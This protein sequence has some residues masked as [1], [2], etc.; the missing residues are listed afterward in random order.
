MHPLSLFIKAL[1]FPRICFYKLGQVQ[2]FNRSETDLVSFCASGPFEQMAAERPSFLRNSAQKWLS[3]AWLSPSWNCQSFRCS[4]SVTPKHCMLGIGIVILS[5]APFSGGNLFNIAEDESCWQIGDGSNFLQSI[6]DLLKSSYPSL[7][8]PPA[9]NS[10]PTHA[11][12]KAACIGSRSSIYVALTISSISYLYS[13]CDSVPCRSITT[14]VQQYWCQLFQ[15]CQS[16]RHFSG[17]KSKRS[18]QTTSDVE[19]PR[20]IQLQGINQDASKR[21]NCWKDWI[22]F[23]WSQQKNWIHKNYP[24]CATRKMSPFLMAVIGPGMARNWMKTGDLVTFASANF[25]ETIVSQG[26]DKLP[27]ETGASGS[28]M[29]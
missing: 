1:R 20:H 23:V 19:L 21:R 29:P 26:K 25:L 5:Q 14:A 3:E 4:T 24:D 2:P 7:Q 10:S 27:Y 15:S 8:R 17:G 28:L 12:L 6:Y 22:H 9:N 18:H 16:T 13:E 11:T